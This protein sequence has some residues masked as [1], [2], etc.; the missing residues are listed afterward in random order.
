MRKITWAL[1]C[2]LCCSFSTK[3]CRS[4][5]ELFAEGAPKFA[6]KLEFGLETSP[7]ESDMI[8]HYKQ[9]P[10]R[11]ESRKLDRGTRVYWRVWSSNR[12]ISQRAAKSP[13]RRATNFDVCRCSH[14]GAEVTCMKTNRHTLWAFDKSGFPR[15]SWK[16]ALQWSNSFININLLKW[17]HKVSLR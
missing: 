5:L 10:K 3:S 8:F 4:A 1:N 2:A 12:L 15:I 9:Q 17:L 13:A 6:P 11:L 14:S 16:I 7:K